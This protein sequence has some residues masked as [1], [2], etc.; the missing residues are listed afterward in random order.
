MRADSAQKTLIRRI[1]ASPA[2][3]RSVIQALWGTLI[4]H[5]HHAEQPVS[6]TDDRHAQNGSRHE[7]RLLVELTVEPC[8]RIRIRDVDRSAGLGGGTDYANAQRNP[9]FHELPG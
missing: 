5:L 7:S 8:V 4:Q 9:D 1:K 6:L 3:I 2:R